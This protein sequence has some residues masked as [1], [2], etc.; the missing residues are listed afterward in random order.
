[1]TWTKRTASIPEVTFDD[2]GYGSGTRGLLSYDDGLSFHPDTDSII[3]QAQN[4]SWNPV[5][6]AG[7][8][9]RVGFGNTIQLPNG[10]C[11]RVAWLEE[12]QEELQVA[13]VHGRS[14]WH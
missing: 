1:M 10:T 3:I 7:G 12:V 8:P 6:R 4:D 5:C 2:D 11:E 13:V 14:P 9:C